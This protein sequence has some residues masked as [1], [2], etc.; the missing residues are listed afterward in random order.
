[1][2]R[3]GDWLTYDLACG[4][5]EKRNIHSDHHFPLEAACHHLTEGHIRY[6]LSFQ[7]RHCKSCGHGRFTDTVEVTK[8]EY[9]AFCA[10]TGGYYT[11]G[12]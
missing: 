2:K 8:A 5:T 12:S 10:G 4:G 11:G 1:M 3:V 9:D 7:I 6:T